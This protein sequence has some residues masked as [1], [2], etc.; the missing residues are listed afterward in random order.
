V[1]NID[2]V[3]TSGVAYRL[4]TRA[5]RWRRRDDCAISG[6]WS[7]AV[8]LDAA[9]STARGWVA[10][11]GY[12]N[13]W[14]ETVVRDFE[15]DGVGPVDLGYDWTSYTESG[16]DFV[17]VFV[18]QDGVESVLAV[19]DGT[20]S[21][22]AV[23]SLESYLQPGT[24]TVGFRLRTDSGWSN[25]D[26]KFVAPCSAFAIDELSVSGGGEAYAADFEL[27]R[28]GWYQARNDADNPLTEYWLVENRQPTGFDTNLHGAGLVV[29]HVD[30]DVMNSSLRNTGGSSGDTTRGVVVEEA[31]GQFD[32]LQNP[33]N[34]GDAGD[35]WP[36]SLV[37][38]DFDCQTV[39]A[40]TNNS[41]SD[42][43]AGMELLSMVG[44]TIQARLSAGDLPPVLSPDDAD[45]V[46]T[47]EPTVVLASST[48]LQPGMSARLL[49][50]GE[51]PIEATDVEWID[52]DRA[53]LEFPTSNLPTGYY[54]LVVENP[55]GQTALLE[56]GVYRSPSATDAPALPRTPGRFA[57]DQNFPNPFN[58]STTIRFEVRVAATVD[59]AVFD[60]RGR[61]VATLHRGPI[62]A[63][64]QERT[65]A[66]RDDEGRSVASGMYFV[67][68]SGPGFTASRKMMLAK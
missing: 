46:L 40:A 56:N 32:L 5:D 61:R 4:S 8:G 29:Y 10:A 15:Y 13:G 19:Y 57:L 39:P 65:W 58:P 25:E 36:G 63:G 50:T 27:N 11:A 30:E 23:H 31:D 2:P 37:R 26:G 51:A 43:G 47:G 33:G 1:L 24:Y 48:G 59:L 68:L 18:R 7:L 17:F 66:G 42:T 60:V 3:Q 41:G 20:G 34:R 67:R 22:S 28:G 54:D 9:Q 14:V 64:F 16:F 49:R 6:S 35:V 21:G 12:G 55:D 38:L 53:R 44:G 45:T 62:E 52:Y